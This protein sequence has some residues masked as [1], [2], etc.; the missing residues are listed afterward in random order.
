MKL[1]NKFD[2]NAYH[3]FKKKQSNLHECVLNNTN[4]VFLQDAE[5]FL[6]L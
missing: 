1:Q 4:P 2:G 5:T 6:T 3:N